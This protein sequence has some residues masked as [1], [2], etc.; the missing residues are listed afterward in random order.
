[1]ASTG[2]ASEAARLR[3]LGA[4]DVVDRAVTSADPGKPLEREAWAGAVDCVGGATLAYVLRTLRYGAAVAASGNTG[5]VAL[6]TTVFPFILRGVAL[7]GID[8]VKYPIAERRAL[9]HRLSMDLRPRQLEAI[10]TEETDLSGLPD[11]LDR[12]L[13]GRQTGRTLVRMSAA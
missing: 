9:W 10:A 11:A 13:S 7:L 3:D 6:T 2:K 4:S 12:V 8:S 5:G 1:M